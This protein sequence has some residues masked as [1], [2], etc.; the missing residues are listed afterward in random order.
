MRDPP[1]NQTPVILCPKTEF[2]AEIRF[3][4][5]IYDVIQF[6]PLCRLTRNHTECVRHE[7]HSFN[8]GPPMLTLCYNCLCKQFSFFQKGSSGLHCFI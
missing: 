7:Q 6:P 3:S 5:F 8:N 4:T 1:I 2:V